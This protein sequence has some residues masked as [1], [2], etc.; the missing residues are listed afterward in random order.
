MKIFLSILVVAALLLAGGIYLDKNQGSSGLTLESL[1]DKKEEKK[2]ELQDY[3]PAPDFAGI[4]AWLNSEPLALADLKGKVVLVDFWTYSCINCVRTFPHI[5]GWYEKYKDQ[6]L[7]VVGVHTP[8]FPFEKDTA[9]VQTALKR[10]NIAYP[11]AQDNDYATWGAYKNQYWPA[12]YLINKEGRIVYT[13]FGEGEYDVTENM[14]RLALGLEKAD[15]PADE[16]SA[17]RIGSPEMYFGRARLENLTTKQNPVTI[18]HDYTWPKDIAFNSFALDGRWEFGE[19]FARL[20]SDT[21]KIK[22]RFS[23]GKI[24]MVADNPDQEATLKI[25]VD[26]RPGSEI[27]V[28]GSQLYTLFDSA[29]YREHIIEIEIQGAGFRAFTFTFG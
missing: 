25:S 29:E 13:H 2:T 28:K 21:G 16:E 23:S 7:V 10:F 22:L 4:S 27:K 12:H 8:E 19:E 6:G 11:V 20:L 14:I 24:F 17:G 15:M 5:S 3:G 1:L 26:G 18:A 9:N